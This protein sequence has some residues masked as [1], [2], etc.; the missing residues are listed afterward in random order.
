M[1]ISLS[2]HGF[3]YIHNFSFLLLNKYFG[4]Y[5]SKFLYNDKNGKIGGRK[6]TEVWEI[7]LYCSLERAQPAKWIWT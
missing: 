6:E 3:L 1:K 5:F 4:I 7:K 2:T